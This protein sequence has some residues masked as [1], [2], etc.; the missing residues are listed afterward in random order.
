MTLFPLS[1]PDANAGIANPF[2]TEPWTPRKKGDPERGIAFL[3]IRYANYFRLLRMSLAMMRRW[4][5]L[6]PS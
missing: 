1:D 5:W 6:V 3:L 2:F 4:T